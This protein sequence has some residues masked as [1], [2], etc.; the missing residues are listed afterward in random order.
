MNAISRKLQ[1]GTAACAMAVAATLTPAVVAQADP[2]A[3][4]PL[5]SLGGAAGGGSVLCAPVGSTD[6]SANIITNSPFFNA[7]STN[8]AST[9]VAGPSASASI[10]PSGTIWQ[11]NLWWIGTPNPNPPPQTV[12]LTWYPLNLLP[13]SIRPLFSWFYN[14]NYQACVGGITIRIGPYGA[15]T[16]SYGHGCA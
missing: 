3:P 14:M 11:N 15:V 7:P 1:T 6:C 8:N 5:A 13:A 9:T 4:I 10:S 12:I 2:A 16:T